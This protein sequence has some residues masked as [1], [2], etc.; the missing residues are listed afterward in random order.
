MLVVMLASH[1]VYLKVNWDRFVVTLAFHRNLNL[2][3][4]LHIKFSYHG[5]SG[6]I[7][8]AVLNVRLKQIVSLRQCKKQLGI[9][10]STVC[11]STGLQR[12]IDKN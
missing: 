8:I 10:L 1:T 9:H 6:S 12:V 5:S 11:Y 4:A 3:F 2:S 7:M